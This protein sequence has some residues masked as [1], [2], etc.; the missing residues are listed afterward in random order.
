LIFFQD[1]L[2]RDKKQ[3]EEMELLEMLRLQEEHRK[4]KEMEELRI[5][6]S[7][8]PSYGD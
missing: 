8:P 5:N 1:Q 6:R 7:P 4:I 3:R 2:E